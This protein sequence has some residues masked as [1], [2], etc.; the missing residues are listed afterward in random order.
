MTLPFGLTVTLVRNTKSGV[1][2]DGNDVY[3]ATN[4]KVPGC[5]FA[6]AGSVETLGNQDTVTS[7]P[8][9][10][11]P[12]GTVVAAI[13]QIII[14]T[15]GTFEVDGE[16]ADWGSHPMTGWTPSNNIVLKLRQVTG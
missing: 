6:P 11:L 3:T 8:Q 10:Y 12:S 13:D 9:L 2:A 14:P 15:Q 4:V 7:T 16:P 1:D 5:A